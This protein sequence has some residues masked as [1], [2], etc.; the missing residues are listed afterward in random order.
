MYLVTAKHV[1]VPGE[2]LK[3]FARVTMLDGQVK[4]EPVGP[5]TRHPTEDVA[6]TCL[7]HQQRYWWKLG[8]IP[9]SSFLPEGPE[10]DHVMLGE[11]V[12]FIGLLR[13]LPEM[14]ADGMPMVRTGTLGRLNQK[15]VPIRVSPTL[16]VPGTAHLIDC[17]SYRGMSGAPCFVQ[18]LLV[19]AQPDKRTGEPVTLK[20]ETHLLGLVSAHFDD[21]E[22]TTVGN[23]SLSVPVHTGV[24]IVT[25]VR[26]IRETLEDPISWKI[27]SG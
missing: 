1:V 17:R 6:V 13:N 21:R 18:R 7:T 4:D 16:T 9:A 22:T 19:R 3:T 25:P 14:A 11:D 12:L 23:M 2:H 24:G 10:D 5:W 20:T 15:K 27:E 8:H 26:F